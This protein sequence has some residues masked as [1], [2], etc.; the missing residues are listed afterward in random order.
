MG[1][2]H[3]SKS[4]AFNKAIRNA[5]RSAST[6]ME[7][8]MIPYVDSSIEDRYPPQDLLDCVRA[9]W[10]KL[11]PQD[12]EILEFIFVERLTFETLAEKLNIKAKSY[13]WR[14]TRIAL[15]KLKI[16]LLED[17]QFIEIALNKGINI[18]ENME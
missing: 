4:Y 12:R 14:K 13:A 7:L 11:S 17:E 1:K 10:E 9:C 8:L 3:N 6:E 16:L 15:Q 2:Y 5:E 18:N